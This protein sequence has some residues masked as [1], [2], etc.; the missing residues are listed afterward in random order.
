MI[1]GRGNRPSPTPGRCTLAEAIRLAGS[2]ARRANGRAAVTSLIDYP[3]GGFPASWTIPAGPSG[4]AV[5][6]K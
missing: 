5:A 2:F 4:S 6:W 3:A 1:T